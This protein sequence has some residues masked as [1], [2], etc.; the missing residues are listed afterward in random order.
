[1]QETLGFLCCANQ[2]QMW[3]PKTAGNLEGEGI[4]GRGLTHL[5][6]MFVCFQLI[7]DYTLNNA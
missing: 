5:Y 1:M 7:L 6:R 2:A 3:T 4:G